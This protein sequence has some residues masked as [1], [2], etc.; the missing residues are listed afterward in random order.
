MDYAF[1]SSPLLTLLRLQN[2]LNSTATEALQF[3]APGT[4]VIALDNRGILSFAP[5]TASVGIANLFLSF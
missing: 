3:F 2:L 5:Y 1:G 4:P